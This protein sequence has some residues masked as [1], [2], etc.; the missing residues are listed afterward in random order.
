MGK[1][2]FKEAKGKERTT[3]RKGRVVRNLGLNMA[4]NREE[5]TRK[6]T[7]KK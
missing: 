4:I 2:M 3:I 6:L 1:N 7:K 5:A